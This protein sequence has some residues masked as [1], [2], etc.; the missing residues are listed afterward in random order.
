ME[1]HQVTLL[2]KLSKLTSQR[3]AVSLLS[4]RKYG[5][6]SPLATSYTQTPGHV[7]KSLHLKNCEIRSSLIEVLRRLG[8]VMPINS[9]IPNK[10]SMNARQ[11]HHRC[12]TTKLY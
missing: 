4:C 3:E 12:S 10:H 8:E 11:T 6:R 1:R 5:L 2:V 7:P 9:F